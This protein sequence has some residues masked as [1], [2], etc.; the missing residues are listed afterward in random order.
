MPV[1]IGK[2]MSDTAANNYAG[3]WQTFTAGSQAYTAF[4]DAFCG[5]FPD[6]IDPVN[7]PIITAAFTGVN[8]FDTAVKIADGFFAFPPNVQDGMA[9]TT[10]LNFPDALGASAFASLF[11]EPL[12]LTQPTTLS[13]NTHDY[14]VANAG[15]VEFL[16][17]I[18]GALSDS[19]ITAAAAALSTP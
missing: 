5:T 9:L 19:T 2:F 6:C 12:L 1:A 18:G 17:V 11:L 8:R 13:A 14:F 3:D 15:N 4:H 16:D 10:G 7:G